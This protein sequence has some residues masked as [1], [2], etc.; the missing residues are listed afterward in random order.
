MAALTRR[1]SE[2]RQKA[3]LRFFMENPRA[4]GEEAQLA[5]TSGRLTGKNDS[6]PMGL[7]MLYRLKREAEVMAARQVNDTPAAAG[8]PVPH[9]GEKLEALRKLAHDVKE[10][11]AALPDVVEVHIRREGSRIVRLRATEEEL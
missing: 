10:L 4:T 6:P 7:G 11:L 5:L 3:V 8:T 1:E 9:N 2:D